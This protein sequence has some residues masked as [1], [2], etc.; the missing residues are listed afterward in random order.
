MG[1][2]VMTKSA[3]RTR[4]ETVVKRS[5]CLELESDSNATVFE[6]SH[7]RRRARRVTT[8][9][10]ERSDCGSDVDAHRRAMMGYSR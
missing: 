8:T 9:Y 6:L 1:V 10:I 3:P 5:R 4:F 2:L 7:G